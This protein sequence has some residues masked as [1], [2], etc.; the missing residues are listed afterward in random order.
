MRRNNS[1]TQFAYENTKEKERSEYY[2]KVTVETPLR[3]LLPRC[4]IGLC[5]SGK[6]EPS[7]QRMTLQKLPALPLS[8]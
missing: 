1:E 6:S 2:N 8:S 3:N 5:L 4:A 7:Q